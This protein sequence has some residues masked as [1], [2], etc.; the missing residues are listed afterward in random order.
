[1]SDPKKL[2]ASVV[3]SLPPP[4]AKK[5]PA[6]GEEMEEDAGGGVSAMDSFKAAF[7]DGD[8]KGMFEALKTALEYCHD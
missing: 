4:G 3:G 8:T 7:E 5:K 2:A 6:E 1:M